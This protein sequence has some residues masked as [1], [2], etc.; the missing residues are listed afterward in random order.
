MNRNNAKKLL[1]VLPVVKAFAEGKEVQ[2]FNG[3]AWVTACSPKFDSEADCYRIK[4]EPIV[5]YKN[6]YKDLEGSEYIAGSC[7][8]DEDAA[9]RCSMS[10]NYVRTA[11]FIEQ[12]D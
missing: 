6:V 7:Y 5:V 10:G 1:A 3:D 12:V 11:R 9:K 2:V 8:Y 4:P